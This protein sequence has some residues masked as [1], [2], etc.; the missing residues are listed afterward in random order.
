[1]TDVFLEYHTDDPELVKLA[2][3][4][5]QLT[6]ENFWQYSV[7]ELLSRTGKRRQ[8]LMGTVH[9]AALAVCRNIRCVE[10]N[11]P[12]IVRTRTDLPTKPWLYS[13]YRCLTCIQA[14]LAEE[15]RREAEKE[16]IEN[17]RLMAVLEVLKSNQD[18][19]D[20]RLIPYYDAIVACSVMI[21]SESAC[22]SGDIGRLNQL[23]LCASDGLARRLAA[24]LHSR[25]I[26]RF[27][28]STGVEAL[29]S[30]SK[31]ASDYQYWALMVDWRFAPSV[32][33]SSFG[34]VLRQ[35]NAVIEN[36]KGT[37]EFV[38]AVR[39]IWWETSRDAIE[40]HLR[41][42]LRQYGMPEFSVGEKFKES[43]DYLL[44]R[45]SVPKARYII[46]RV[47]KNA[48][49]L[50]TRVDFNR[51]RAINTIPGAIIRDCDRAIADN[52]N[53]NGYTYKWD[54][55]EPQLFTFIFD[56]LLRTGIAG[57][58]LTSGVLLEQVLKQQ[59]EERYMFA[60]GSETVQ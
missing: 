36:S 10:C 60:P 18:P 41:L 19:Y 38:Q 56:R 54:T 50:S 57:F 22:E 14:E 43:F 58:R 51:P 44:E 28:E 8:E 47:A 20:Y 23:G 16:A 39:Q 52:W 48:A 2:E 25:R 5:W 11:S 32:D 40:Q 27:G 49:A 17:Q 15:R 31:D 3:D 34:N 21:Q 9:A 53:I 42:Q 45:F 7:K 12:F 29:S 13:T 30:N 59:W 46:Y 6:P 4:F 24:Q 37:D 55:E 33:Q 26:F 1:M 35:L